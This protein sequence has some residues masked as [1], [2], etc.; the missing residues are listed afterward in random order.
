MEDENKRIAIYGIILL[1]IIF[2]LVLGI[3]ITR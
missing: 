2:L 3:D 1:T